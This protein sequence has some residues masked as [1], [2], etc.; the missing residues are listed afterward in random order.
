MADE[1]GRPVSDLLGKLRREELSRTRI[2]LSQETGL[3]ARDAAPG[4]TVSGVYRRRMD[5]ASGR[6]AMIDDG[7]GF[8]LG[9]W[10]RALESH[11]DEMVKGVMT[12]GGGVDWALGRKR[13]LGL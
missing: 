6:F 9:P 3:A 10:T 8:Q 1:T 12:P 13:G 5:L 4:D 11:R 7:L 2:A